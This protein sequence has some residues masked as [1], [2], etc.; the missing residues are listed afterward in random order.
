MTPPGPTS[1]VPSV[2][3]TLSSWRWARGGDRV[4]PGPLCSGRHLNS[5][6][7]R[8]RPQVCPETNQVLINIGL[9]L[10]AFPSPTEEGQLR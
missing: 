1:F 2:T 6:P 3:M 10:L 5:C 4:G 9:L 7:W 8:P